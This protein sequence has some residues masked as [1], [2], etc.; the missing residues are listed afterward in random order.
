[1][2]NYYIAEVKDNDDSHTIPPSLKEGKVQIYIEHLMSGVLNPLDL[3]WAKSD[4]EMTSN[5]PN[6][7]DYI[8]VWFED[9]KYWRNAYYGNKVDLKLLG[10]HKEFELLIKPKLLASGITVTGT[11]PNV[12]Y[13]FYPTL[14]ALGA[15]IKPVTDGMC[16]GVCSSATTKE[17]FLF[18]STGVFIFIDSLGKVTIKTT[19]G[20]EINAGGV[21]ESMV[22][23]NTLKT[24]IEQQIIMIFNTH[25]H[26]YI[27]PLIPLPGPPAPTLPPVTP[28]V[29]GN[30][31]SI[32]NK[33]D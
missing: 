32:K 1:M 5:I 14:D 27:F 25:L 11:Y 24:Y 3:P 31:L 9:V 33:N 20:T 23:G 26:S 18:H 17:I 19:M 10:M 2:P 29:T 13:Q 15:V 7:G 21:V 30:Y 4:R 22:L 6:I 28:M 12:K 16:I 8:W